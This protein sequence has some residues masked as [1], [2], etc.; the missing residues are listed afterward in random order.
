MTS[1]SRAPIIPQIISAEKG[2]AKN[3][4]ADFAR[5]VESIRLT[6]SNELLSAIAHKK[7]QAVQ[8]PVGIPA[9]LDVVEGQAPESSTGLSREM[10]WG[11]I[12][13]LLLLVIYFAITTIFPK[14][15]KR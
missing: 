14:K 7:S 9:H 12:G 6:A 4:N 15:R 2:K 5:T 11:I 10:I 13:A 1:K 3:Y 8:T